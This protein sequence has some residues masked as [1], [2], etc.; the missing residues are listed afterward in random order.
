[1][2][3]EGA[4][5]DSEVLLEELMFIILISLVLLYLILA[6]QFESLIQPLIVIL[7]VPV[8]WFGVFVL[9]YILRESINLIA[10]IGL[11]VMSGIVVNDAI[12]KIDMMNQAYKNGSTKRAA[13]HLAGQRRLRAIIMTSLTTILALVPILFSEGLGA[14]LQTPLVIAVIGGLLLGTWASLYLI[15]VL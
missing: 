9:L 12:L 3:F 1:M 2:S 14:E 7:T 15:P 6:A 13:I 4:G 10:L 8:A 5:F 11:V